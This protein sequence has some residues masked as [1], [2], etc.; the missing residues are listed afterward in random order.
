MRPM[1]T[2]GLLLTI[3]HEILAQY[4]VKVWYLLILMIFIFVIAE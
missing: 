1:K 4:Q 2:Q 3:F